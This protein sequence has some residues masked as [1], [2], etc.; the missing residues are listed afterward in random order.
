MLVRSYWPSTDL[1]WPQGYWP[2]YPPSLISVASEGQSS[3]SGTLRAKGFLN[4]SVGGTSA[5][6]GTLALPAG[7]GAGSASGTSTVVGILQGIAK[8]VG[9]SSGQST[10]TGFLSGFADV[11]GQSTGISTV[12][13]I[14]SAVGYLSGSVSGS[15]NAAA[16]IP[17][18]LGDSI[19]MLSAGIWRKSQPN[20]I[21]FVLTDSDGVEV[22][23]LGSSFTLQ[24]R[25]IG[26]SFV[27]GNG[28]KSEVGLGWY[29]Y[30]STINEANT[31]G[32]VAI[33]VTNAGIQQQNLEYV[34]EDRVVVGI[35]FEYTLTNTS[36]NQPIVGA[37]ISFSTSP[38][39]EDTI[40]NGITDAFG[41]A[42]DLNG[43]LPRLTA[44]SYY[45]F[46]Y[47]PGFIFANPD[48]ETVSA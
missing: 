38:A 23:G 36:N 1:Y 39:P 27:T 15:S 48:L 6:T 7:F 18:I 32:P 24:I 10:A 33:V 35:S 29:Q 31:S 5:V 25:K 37:D 16:A 42:R 47:K 40:W 21:L 4:G 45:V 9:S 28:T 11:V 8:T 44:G 41:V 12:S 13:A 14:I 34:V 26:G 19:P 43:N 46:S 22:T 30:I 17:D 3:V 20:T 2:E